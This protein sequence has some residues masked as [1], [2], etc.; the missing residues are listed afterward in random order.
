MLMRLMSGIPQQPFLAGC[1]SQRLCVLRQAALPFELAPDCFLGK[2]KLLL[3]TE[4]VM[5]CFRGTCMKLAF[6]MY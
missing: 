3:W 5:Q 2:Q 4:A 1:L 6:N